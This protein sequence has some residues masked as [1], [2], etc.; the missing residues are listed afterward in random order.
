MSFDDIPEDRVESY[1]CQDDL[2]EGSMIVSADGSWKCD[3]CDWSSESHLKGDDQY[4]A[5][6]GVE[7]C[8]RC[9]DA[10]EERINFDH[11]THLC[12]ICSAPLRKLNFVGIIYGCKKCKEVIGMGTDGLMGSI[13]DT[14]YTGE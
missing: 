5:M 10:E 13:P 8:A 3:T 1:P 14:V 2:C 4:C 6:H 9:R 12:P 7:E 11:R